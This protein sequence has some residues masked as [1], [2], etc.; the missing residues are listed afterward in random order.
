MRQ[1]AEAAIDIS[2]TRISDGADDLLPL[3]CEFGKF[4]KAILAHE[5]NA[6]LLVQAREVFVD[7]LP[8]A[9][10]VEDFEHNVLAH[11]HCDA[12]VEEVAGVDYDR[13]S[14][15]AIAMRE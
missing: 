11:G 15:M 14:P 7:V 12:R 6:L 3:T 13:Y 4:L 1:A 5:P 9:L 2:F 10:A 8:D